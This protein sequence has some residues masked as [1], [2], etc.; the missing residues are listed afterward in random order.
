MP[1]PRLFMALSSVSLVL[2]VGDVSRAQEAAAPAPAPGAPART[3]ANDWEDFNHYVRVARPDLANAYGTSLLNSVPDDGKLLEI[4]ESGNYADFEKTLERAVRVETLKDL[5]TQMIRRIQAARIQRSREPD[6]IVADIRKLAEGER[7][8]VNALARLKASGEYAAPHLLSILLKPEE[9]K[10]HPYVLTAMAAI[11]RPLVYPLSV[12]LPDLEAVPQGQVAQVLVEIGYPRALPYMKQVI[13]NPKTE[14]HARE[15]VQK[16]FTELA[17]SSSLPANVTAAE[18]FY[19][20]AQNYYQAGTAGPSALGLGPQDPSGIVWSYTPGNKSLVAIEVPAGIFGDALALRAAQTALTLSPQMD[21]ALSLWLMANLRRENHLAQGQIDRSY[22]SHML[23]P[24]FYIEMAG[25]L[26]QHDV[27]DRALAD[28]DADLALDAIAA[29]D[30]TAGTAA[31]VNQE[32]G[33]QPLLR[34]LSYADRRVRFQA[35][36]ALANAR[37]AEEF[38][39]SYRVVPVMSEALRQGDIRN[40]LVLTSEQSAS[41]TTAATIKEL[42]YEVIAGTKLDDLLERVNSGPGM[43]IIVLG[44]TPGQV[45]ALLPQIDLQYKL[46]SVPVVCLAANSADQIEFN[47]VLNGRTNITV[48]LASG[49]SKDLTGAVENATKAYAGKALTPEES[50]KFSTAALAQLRAIAAGISANVYKITDAQPA[51]VAALADKRPEVAGEAARVLAM[52]P[53]PEAQQAVGDA[54]LDVSA[55]IEM[56]V[57][58]LDALANSAKHQG[59]L[60]NPQQ[61]EKILETVKTSQGDLAIAAARAHGALTL[62]TSNVV[63]L[64]AK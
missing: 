19:T 39:G 46:A 58:F 40:A 37:P 45:E 25:P 32:G 64:I 42:G 54:A 52:I 51:L 49:E 43:D 29:L 22:P 6:R 10:L 7:A 61:L 33:A 27:L 57:L 62:P 28:K 15:I 17:K 41:N 21:Q 3:P 34:A 14:P 38:P 47:R 13:D 8:A 30:A 2:A 12:A 24:K 63:Q 11:G 59:N 4:I 55:A 53:G 35:A 18:L 31:L 26:R 23:P 16:A 9:A 44:L 5:T 60:L 1:N 20:L 36:F 48:S 56:R 50:L